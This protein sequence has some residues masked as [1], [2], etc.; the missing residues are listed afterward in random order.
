MLFV[1]VSTPCPPQV[2]SLLPLVASPF[3]QQHVSEV[4]DVIRR[5]FRAIDTARESAGD[6]PYLHLSVDKAK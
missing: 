6:N 2:S 5:D 1:K 3:L 4:I